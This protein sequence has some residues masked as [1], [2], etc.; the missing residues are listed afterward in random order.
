MSHL[1][2]LEALP[3]GWDPTLVVVP[4][5]RHIDFYD[6]TELIPFDQLEKFFADNL[7]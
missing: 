4:G 5:A 3:G 2:A 7:A 6:R 1:A